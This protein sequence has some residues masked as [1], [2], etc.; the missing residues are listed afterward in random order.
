MPPDLDLRDDLDG[1]AALAAALGVVVS[2]DNA[3]AAIAGAIG[4]R[5]FVL[6]PAHAFT[7]LGTDRWPWLPTVRLFERRRDETWQ[8]AMT[9]LA[10][11][12]TDR[13]TPATA[14]A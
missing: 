7:T 2:V 10:A 6:S 12:L 3:V 1:V 5:T 8:P 9:A 13:A 11:A 4:A 14:P